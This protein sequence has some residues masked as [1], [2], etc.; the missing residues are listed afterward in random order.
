MI[1]RLRTAIDHLSRLDNPYLDEL[2]EEDIND[3]FLE[4]SLFF[5]CTVKSHEIP[6]FIDVANYLAGRVLPKAL[7][8]HKKKEFFSDLR[9]YF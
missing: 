1:W 8:H 4:E 6:W 5:V 2:H 9:H 3:K 7:D